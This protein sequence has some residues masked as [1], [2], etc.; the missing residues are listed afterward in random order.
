MARMIMIE[1]SRWKELR[2]KL[3]SDL[4]LDKFKA[5]HRNETL[6]DLHRSFNYKVCRF[7][8]DVEKA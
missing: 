2:D 5:D 8:D 3:R 7:F 4:E 6:G 1:E